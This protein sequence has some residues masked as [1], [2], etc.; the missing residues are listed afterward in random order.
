MENNGQEEWIMH[1]DPPLHAGGTIELDC[2]MPVEGGRGGDGKPQKAGALVEVAR[3][4]AALRPIGPERY[5]GSLGVRRP[6]DW[7]GRF[8]PLPGTD[9]IGDESFVKSWGNLPAEPLTL[10]G[11]S[12]FVRD[13]RA[14]ILTGPAPARIVVKPTVALQLESGRIAVVVEAELSENA[15][16]LSRLEAELPDNLILN[17]VTVEGLADWSVTPDHRLRLV[18]GR[19]VASQRRRLRL[20]AVIPMSE[21]PLKTGSRHHRIRVPWIGWEGSEGQAGFLAISSISKPEIQG[22]PGSTLITSE[23]S[24]TVGKVPSPRHRQT[25]RIDD[26]RTLG[27]IVWESIPARVSVS[28]ESQVTIHPDSAEWV[29]VLR[30]D[31]LGGSLDAIHLKMPAAWAASAELRLA[32]SQFHLTTATRDD[33]A[34]WTITPERP[35]WGTQRFVLR[36]S[37][38]LGSDREII[39]PKVSPLG[40]GA[41]NAMLRVVNATGRPLTIE[42][43]TGLDR[44][45]E[46]DRFRAR[47]FAIDVGNPIGA[48][49]VSQESWILR[50]QLPRNGLEAVESQG[51][52]ARVTSAELMI[53]ALP[54]RSSV[55]RAVY[56]TVAGAGAD[57]S[58]ELPSGSSV[59]WAAVDSNAVTPLK[60]SSGTLSIPLDDSRQSRVGLIWRCAAPSAGTGWPLDLPRAGPGPVTTL[61]AVYTP[62]PMVIQGDLGG[63]EPISIARLEMARADSLTRSI[64]DFVAKIDRSSG[65]DHEKL[66]SLLISQELALRSADRSHQRVDPAGAKTP[67]D[68][69]GR[70]S[71][72]IQSARPPPS[73]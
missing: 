12:R 9:P 10:C 68:R 54:D 59:L 39:H 53:V 56:E 5:F 11:T 41:V 52:R 70:N 43:S 27:E 58:I 69:P 3:Q 46:G 28:I 35:I 40:P 4:L 51:G 15:G 50:L 62:T 22:S 60:S 24:G 20:S 6:G 29:A 73:S 21:D 13:C 44:I 33:F 31:V 8:N 19:P 16:H 26:A 61:V 66:V 36:S 57:L 34:T 64:E 25:Y 17:E 47:E 71:E 2:W 37:R 18:F 23:I 49:R 1:V 48:F 14:S 45:A 55:G 7:T 72:M 65:R 67:D 38:P 42:N 32:G 63:L 30:Y